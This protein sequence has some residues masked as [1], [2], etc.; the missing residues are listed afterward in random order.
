[1]EII[2]NKYYIGSTQSHKVNQINFQCS[3]SLKNSWIY[4]PGEYSSLYNN[5]YLASQTQLF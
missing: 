2:L 1:M 3:V 4:F 5:N